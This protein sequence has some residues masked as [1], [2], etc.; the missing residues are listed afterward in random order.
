M[1]V[2]K[3]GFNTCFLK[4]REAQKEQSKFLHSIDKLQQNGII[5]AVSPVGTVTSD[6][7]TSCC[8]EPNML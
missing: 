8:V 4:M 6:L 5:T 3:F 2:V 1:Q 7:A